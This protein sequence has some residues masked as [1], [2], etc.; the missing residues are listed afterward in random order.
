MDVYVSRRPKR[1][2]A[3]PVTVLPGCRCSDETEQPH[4]IARPLARSH[5]YTQTQIYVSSRFAEPQT[6]LLGRP[7]VPK[8]SMADWR[9]SHLSLQRGPLVSA[10]MP[11]RRGRTPRR[12]QGLAA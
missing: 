11:G 1:S 2:L 6:V 12:L 8:V 7:D 3:V 10:A 4:V 9:L 5:T